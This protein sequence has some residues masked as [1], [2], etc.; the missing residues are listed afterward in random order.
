MNAQNDKEK[1][2]KDMAMTKSKLNDIRKQ[3]EEDQG[4][5]DTS[6]PTQ[7]IGQGRFARSIAD[8]RAL[9]KHI[10]RMRDSMRQC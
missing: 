5:Y 10:D 7:D 1:E 6:G 4:V 3:M 8:R 9:L 2:E